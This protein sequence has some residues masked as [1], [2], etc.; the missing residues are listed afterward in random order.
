MERGANENSMASRASVRRLAVPGQVRPSQIA[1]LDLAID[2]M[3]NGLAYSWR[4]AEAAE[5]DHAG[6]SCSSSLKGWRTVWRAE[7]SVRMDTKH[8]SKEQHGKPQCR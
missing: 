5:I 3:I 8:G 4:L 2:V 6:C 1:D 7:L